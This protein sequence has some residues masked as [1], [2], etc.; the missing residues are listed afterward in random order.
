MPDNR[1]NAL[2]DEEMGLAPVDEDADTSG[3]DDT[4]AEFASAREAPVRTK[5]RGA[6]L[7]YL[8][9]AIVALLAVGGFVLLQAF[10]SELGGELNKED[11]QVI[12][13]TRQLGSLQH[14]LATL[15]NQVAGLHSQLATEDSKVERILGEQSS[16]FGERLELTKSEL[17]KSVEQIQRQLS[18][19]R[20][21]VLVA[22]AEYLLSIANQKLHLVGDVKAV[23]AAMEA[24]D[25]R[26]HDSGDPGVFPVREALAEEIDTLKKMNAPDVVGLS[27]KILALENKIRDIPLLLPHSATSEEPALKP[28]EAEPLPNPT[29]AEPGEQGVLDS[30]IENLKGLVTVRR[31]D[32]PIQAILTPEEVEGLRQILLLKLEMTRASLLRGDETMYSGNVRSAQEFVQSHFDRQAA[33]TRELLDELASLAEQKIRIPMPDISKSLSLIRNI[34]RLRLKTEPGQGQ[35]DSQPKEQP[36]GAKP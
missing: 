24:A 17:T 4:A 7:G 22:D 35:Q 36:A 1:E 2:T 30:A 5:P 3:D 20:G 6:W 23:L 25:Q 28:K 15:H 12:E 33:A 8:T 31:T 27:A 10:R 13:L 34:E 21:D 9:L 19:T 14:Q 26:L 11:Q 16:T 29:E 32:R 18:R